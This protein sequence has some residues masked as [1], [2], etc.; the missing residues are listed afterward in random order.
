MSTSDFNDLNPLP[1]SD[2]N[3]QLEKLSIKAFNLALPV[4]KFTFRDERTDD[5]GIDGSLELEINGKSTNLRA[6]VQLKA[7]DSEEKNQDGSISVQITTANLNYLLNGQSPLYILYVVPRNELY[8]IWARDERKRLDNINP[9]WSQ[10]KTVRIRFK[11]LLSNEVLE[12]IHQRIQN[13]ARMQR[14]INDILSSASN[15]ENA[16]FSISL[17][18][19]EI[20]D[21]EQAKEILI[22][23]GRLIVTAGYPEKIRSLSKLLDEE[24]EKSPLILIIRAYAE[25]MLG[26]Y[27]TAFALLSEAQL[28]R[29]VLNEEDKQFLD[30]LRK[31]CEY[32]TGR[33]TLEEFSSF[34]NSYTDKLSGH[35]AQSFRINQ[36]RYA[37][38]TTAD[39][40]QRPE[41]VTKF[42]DLVQEVLSDKSSSSVFKLFAKSVWIEVEGLEIATG[43]FRDLAADAIRVSQGFSS[44]IPEIDRKSKERLRIWLDVRKNALKE[45]E[46]LNHKPLIAS[47]KFSSALVIYHQLTSNYSLAS[48]LSAPIEEIFE[49]Y[50]DDIA[51]SID[52]ALKLLN[53]AIEIF[54]QIDNIEGEIR[55]RLLIADFCE[56]IGRVS[57]AKK[58]AEDVLPKADAF[59]YI[60]QIEHAK[61]HISGNGLKARLNLSGKES[62]PIERELENANWSDEKIRFLAAQ[63]LRIY[64]L[65]DDRYPVMEREY[66]SIRDIAKEKLRWC[67]FIE[68]WQDK[69]HYSSLQT[70]FFKDP[71]RLCV[72]TLHNYQSIIRNPDWKILIPAFKKTYCEKCPDRDPLEKDA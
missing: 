12:E 37:I 51:L 33:I 7:T 28:N 21:A 11:N 49:F 29:D 15:T 70:L 61:E 2:R 24:S 48:V 54:Q 43:L 58:I 64:N 40:Y 34:L 71:E 50:K 30:F 39:P 35:I 44:R 17:E 67:R 8:Y 26:K 52:T 59:G 6:Q 16:I 38:L 4:D 69:A 72:C 18:N 10:Q 22:T 47:L 20:T 46:K 55:A 32:L 62:T 14:Q 68:L 25:E 19:L 56:F 31:N 57:E 66:F 1:I 27:Q 23:S 9:T 45:A 53:E 5:S 63:M 65:P 36:L 42:T 41:V 60:R 13:E 3:K